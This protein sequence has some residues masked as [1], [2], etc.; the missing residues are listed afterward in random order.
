MPKYEL[1]ILIPARNEEWLGRTIQDVLDH[2]TD[3]CEII[4]VLDGAWPVEP[5]PSHPRV[6][7]IHNSISIGQRA[8]QNQAARISKARFICK[9]DAHVAIDKDFD[10]KL[11]QAYEPRTVVV[12]RLFNLHVFDWKCR[13]CGLRTYQGPKPTRC[14]ACQQDPEHYRKVV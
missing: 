10:Q 14:S 8:A 6:T 5:L 2:T 9:M 13:R 3:A 12:P 1:S 4:S 11:I 7:L